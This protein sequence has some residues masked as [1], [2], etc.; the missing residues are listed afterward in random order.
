MQNN[1]FQWTIAR[2][3]QPVNIENINLLC[4]VNVDQIKVNSIQSGA[5]L[6]IGEQICC[7]TKS[8][9]QMEMGPNAYNSGDCNEMRHWL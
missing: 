4:N 2:L 1:M 8:D 6:N 9:M 7:R 3:Q 5:A